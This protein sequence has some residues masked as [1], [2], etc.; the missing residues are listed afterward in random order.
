MF[1]GIGYWRLAWDPHCLI[2]LEQVSSG[3]DSCMRVIILDT[4]SGE[5][6]NSPLQ[7]TCLPVSF[8]A[9]RSRRGCLHPVLRTQKGVLEGPEHKD[10]PEWWWCGD[11]QC[12]HQC[13][14]QRCWFH[15]P[16]D[17]R[18]RCCWWK[19]SMDGDHETAPWAETL[20]ERFDCLR[21]SWTSWCPR[22]RKGKYHLAI[23]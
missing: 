3:K 16:E 18:C 13:Q 12:C 7:I 2:M 14:T 11:S 6:I 20:C 5:N 9:N 4:S 8:H 17:W 21:Q 23:F 1:A 15:R 22:L 10:C 19:H